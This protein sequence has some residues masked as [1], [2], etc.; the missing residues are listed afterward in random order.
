MLSLFPFILLNLHQCG[1]LLKW[2]QRAEAC[3]PFQDRQDWLPL[4]FSG[5]ADVSVIQLKV[6]T[7]E[8]RKAVSLYRILRLGNI[9]LEENL[10]LVRFIC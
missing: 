9:P 5:F 2:K 3:E 6:Y 4:I 8:L 10:Y 7:L 1:T